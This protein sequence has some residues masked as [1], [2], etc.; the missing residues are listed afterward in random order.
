MRYFKIPLC[1]IFHWNVKDRSG[2]KDTCQC[3]NVGSLGQKLGYDN[4][5]EEIFLWYLESFKPPFIFLLSFVKPLWASTRKI[6]FML[7]YRG[8]LQTL[9]LLYFFNWVN[10]TPLPSKMLELHSPPLLSW[11]IHFTPSIFFLC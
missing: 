9:T 1:R 4:T 8:I 6:L 11:N 10:Y 7:V 3:M 5:H 2:L